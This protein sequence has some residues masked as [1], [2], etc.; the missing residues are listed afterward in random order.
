[1]PDIRDLQITALTATRACPR[2]WGW[3]ISPGG[4]YNLPHDKSCDCNGTGHVSVLDAENKYGLRVRCQ[5]A[6][7]AP[8]LDGLSTDTNAPANLQPKLAD[9]P[10]KVCQGLG[11]TP[12][13]DAF[14]W[15]RALRAAQ[16]GFTILLPTR[17]E[18]G[19]AFV[20][21]TSLDG[22]EGRCLQRDDPASAFFG[23]VAEAATALAQE[24]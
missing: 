5:G 14:A 20:S 24:E 12:S 19:T 15:M 18:I 10:C 23:T 2:D 16:I 3:G 13:D 8:C 1:M 21:A 4:T 6:P 7:F 22:I 11:Y 17:I 9:K